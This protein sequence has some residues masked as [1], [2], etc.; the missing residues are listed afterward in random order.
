MK[1]LIE[2]AIRLRNPQFRFDAELTSLMLIQFVWIQSIRLLR[3]LRVLFFFRNPKGASFGSGVSFFYL[4]GIHWGRFLKLGRQV[5][6]SALGHGHV[7]MGDNVS[8]GDFSRIVISTSLNNLGEFIAIGNNVGIGEFAYLGGAGGLEIGNDVIAGQYFSCHPENHVFTDLEKPIR[9]QGVERKGI[10]IGNNCWL[11][12]KVTIL[13]GV[14][15]GDGCIVA[16]GAL[17]NQSFPANSIIGGVP[18]KLIKSR[19]S[20]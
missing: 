11:G 20:A 12:S 19:K 1:M 14:E 8:I 16:A 2:N 13:D 15:L 5:Y 7:E 4:P 9:L 10:K 18:A 3:A 6:I 17:V